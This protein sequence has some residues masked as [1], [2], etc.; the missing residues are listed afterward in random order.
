MAM[1]PIEQI[2]DM[3]QDYA[4][5]AIRT[6]QYKRFI[7]QENGLEDYTE[8]VLFRTAQFDNIREAIID[9][10]WSIY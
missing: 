9:L 4:I 2:M 1:N 5:Q 8:Q 7:D 6:E 10:T 3:I